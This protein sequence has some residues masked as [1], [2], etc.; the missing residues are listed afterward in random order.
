M[1]TREQ[2]L[3]AALRALL[4]AL[5]KNEFESPKLAAAKRMAREAL[6]METTED[7]G[8]ESK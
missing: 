6:S 2:H 3:E 5:D 8:S 4:E 1:N 7:E